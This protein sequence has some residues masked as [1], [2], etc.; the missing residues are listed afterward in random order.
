MTKK[1]IREGK[2]TMEKKLVHKHIK[3]NDDDR[4]AFLTGN[5]MPAGDLE[6]YIWFSFENATQ[7][8]V[9]LFADE[10]GTAAEMARKAGLED[11]AKRLEEGG[12][13]E[14]P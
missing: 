11:L 9:Y 5:S 2:Y 1:I 4:Q 8:V 10:L 12:S 14:I 3:V 13:D 7:G 6:S